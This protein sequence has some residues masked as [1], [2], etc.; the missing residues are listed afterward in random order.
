MRLDFLVFVL[1]VLISAASM[2]QDAVSTPSDT[3]VDIQTD[4]ENSKAESEPEAKSSPWLAVP[5]ISSDPK[6]G[7]SAGGMVGYMIKLDP[8]STSSMVG[9][10]GTYSTTDSLLGGVFLRSFWDQD[11]KR[12]NLFAGGGKVNNDYEDF[13]GS[14]LPVQTTDNVKVFEGRYLQQVKGKWFAGGKGP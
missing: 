5:M 12:L 8:E 11:R 3:D 10:G 14:G 6:V 13:L 4:H 2:A 1:F 9:M 7:T